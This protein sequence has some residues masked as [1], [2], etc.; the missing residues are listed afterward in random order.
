MSEVV[1]A[2]VIE[3]FVDQFLRHKYDNAT[4]IPEIHREWWRWYCDSYPYGALAAPRGHAKTT[5]ITHAASLCEA[6]QGAASYFIIVSDTEEQAKEFLGDIKTELIEN[7]DLIEY[8]GVQP[9][10]KDTETDIICKCDAG[11]FRF[12]AKGAEQKIRGRKWR[13]KRPERVICDDMESDEAVDSKA[14]RTKF[15]RWFQNAL[16]QEI[17]RA[18]V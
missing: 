7:E 18:H 9:L 6:L 15:M 12:L 5:S 3:A 14:R 1:D 11:V 16:L 2:E 13:G 8:F 10:Q 4:E 17:G